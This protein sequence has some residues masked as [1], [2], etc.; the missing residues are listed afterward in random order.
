MLSRKYLRQQS[1]L[2][3]RLL[4]QI[5]LRVLSSREKEKKA[6]WNRIWLLNKTLETRI[7]EPDYFI[8]RPIAL[9]R[10]W[11]ASIKKFVLDVGSYVQILFFLGNKWSVRVK[12]LFYFIKWQM[13][14]PFKFKEIRMTIIQH[15]REHFIVIVIFSPIRLILF[16]CAN[17]QFWSLIGLM[18][19]Y[20]NQEI[21][22]Y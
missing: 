7:A 3:Y 6:T 9:F 20:Y 21:S 16:I 19:K 4:I 5:V 13:L 18:W 11:N 8:W 10:G 15:P 1:S 14:R 12:S 22:A 2:F 17:N